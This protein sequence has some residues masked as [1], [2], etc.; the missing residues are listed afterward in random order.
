MKRAANRKRLFG[1]VLIE[2]VVATLIA[3]II[4]G[5]LL[6]ALS[7][8]S[9]IQASID[10]AIDMSERV[11]IV[12]NQLEKDLAGAFVP[13]QAE[14]KKEK[15]I[16]AIESDAGGFTPRGFSLVM[17]DAKKEKLTKWKDYFFTYGIY[18]FT[19]KGGGSDI[20]P[21]EKQGCPLMGL[22]PDSQR[23]FLIHHT[24]LDTFEQVNKRELELGSIA[25][26]MMVYF[27]SEYGL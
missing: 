6:L 10:K 5:V 26:T 7:Q 23:Y 27:V 8:S 22:S 17:D 19:K 11:A 25:M 15:H 16:L 24:A 14:L 4:S 18:D 13:L 21:L 12:A 20:G 9:R 3:G 2:L 1:F